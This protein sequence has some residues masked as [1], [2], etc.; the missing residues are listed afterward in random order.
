MGGLDGRLERSMEAA[1]MLMEAMGGMGHKYQYELVGHSGET[2][3]IPLVRFGAPP[4]NERERLKVME[5]MH[6][7]AQFC[8]SGDHTVEAAAAAVDSLAKE[9]A[10]ERFVIV[11]SDANLDRYGIPPS[12]LGRVLVSNPNV[13]ASVLFIGSLGNQAEVLK[14]EL[15]VGHG[16]VCLDTKEIPSAIRSIFTS[17]LRV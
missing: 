10:D 4:A 2:P 5:T 7:H 13:T 9:D 15:P 3:S 1:C 8:L 12:K 14:R 6:A 16:F 17:A 11:L